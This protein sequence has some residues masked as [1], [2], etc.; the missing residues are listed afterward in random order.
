[1][2]TAARWTAAAAA[3]GAGTASLSVPLVPSWLGIELAV[4]GLYFDAVEP[5]GLGNCQRMVLTNR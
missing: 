3:G 4:Q 2:Y 5:L 1:V